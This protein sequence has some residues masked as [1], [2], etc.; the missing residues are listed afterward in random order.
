M[1]LADEGWRNSRQ[2]DGYF[3]RPEL[4]EGLAWYLHAFFD[5]AGERREAL[6]GIPYS[7]MVLYADRHGIDGDD[8]DR[9]V[10]IVR[11][12]DGEYISHTAKKINPKG[13]R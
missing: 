1:L 9:F 11:A 8:L 13:K 5:L 3:A 12:L 2:A 4:D 10:G 6:A 7:A